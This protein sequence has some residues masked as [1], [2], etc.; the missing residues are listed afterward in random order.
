MDGILPAAIYESILH[1]VNGKEDL[2]LENEI[3]NIWKKYNAV[4][5]KISEFKNDEDISPED[6]LESIEIAW[7]YLKVSFINTIKKYEVIFRHTINK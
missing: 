4:N 6:S 7:H 2:L 3:E 5:S 1:V